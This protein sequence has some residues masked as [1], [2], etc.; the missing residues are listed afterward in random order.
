MV[1]DQE[2]SILYVL[3]ELEQLIVAYSIDE[4]IGT[5]EERYSTPYILDNEGLSDDQLGAEIV[6]HPYLPVL[7]ISHRGY[8]CIISFDMVDPTI[9]ML[10]QRQVR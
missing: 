1:I 2:N 6:I 9:G 4:N 5:L 3:M 7:Y 8:G 10:G